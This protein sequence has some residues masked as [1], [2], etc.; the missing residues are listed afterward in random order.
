MQSCASES[1]RSIRQEFHGWACLLTT[2]ASLE[3]DA[4]V[5]QLRQDVQ[6][7][8]LQQFPASA[9]LSYQTATMCA[10]T[11][12][13]TRL[14]M[15]VSM[16]LRVA[17]RTAPPNMQLIPVLDACMVDGNSNAGGVH[18]SRLASHRPPQRKKWATATPYGPLDA[19]Q[20]AWAPMHS[21][22]GLLGVRNLHSQG[23]RLLACSAWTEPRSNCAV[24]STSRLA[25]IQLAYMQVL[26]LRNAASHPD[27]LHLGISAR[28]HLRWCKGLWLLSSAETAD[29]MDEK[30]IRYFGE[31][32]KWSGIMSY[33]NFD[34]LR[35]MLS[36]GQQETVQDVKSVTCS[37]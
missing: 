8:L 14:R 19:L 23:S 12:M 32:L 3:R 28:H 30:D 11:S 9:Y 31:Q 33:Q 20:S 5:P 2:L 17:G 25:V 18:L 22:L 16:L 21:C 15:S 29:A 35:L 4:T 36:M 34:E 13:P 26:T 1:L 6:L 10:D 27:A 37:K 7:Q 24:F